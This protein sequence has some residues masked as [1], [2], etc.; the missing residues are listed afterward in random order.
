MTGQDWRSLGL[1]AQIGL[2]RMG[3]MV[4]LAVLLPALGAG[5]LLALASQP[6]SSADTLRQALAQR[7]ARLK[8]PAAA[9]PALPATQRQLAA[10][11]AVLGEP[12]ATEGHVRALFDA[13]RRNEI[14]LGQGEYKLQVDASSQ[15]ERYQIRLP[16]KGRYAAIRS[17]CEA[18]LRELPFASLDELDLK[19]EEVADETLTAMIQFSLHLHPGAASDVAGAAARP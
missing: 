15:T 11:Y 19:R 14:G 8:T 16:I 6:P 1:Q 2:G 3:S 10:F 17:F 5:G 13:A 18:V 9:A 12:S 4:V 7:Q